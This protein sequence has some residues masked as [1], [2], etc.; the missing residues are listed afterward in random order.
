MIIDIPKTLT[1]R[2]GRGARA[3]EKKVRHDDSVF[4]VQ[5]VGV[6]IKAA[7]Q[8]ILHEWRA[9]N[10]ASIVSTLRKYYG[11][12]KTLSVQLS[13]IKKALSLL[14]SPPPAPFFFANS[15]LTAATSPTRHA[16]GRDPFAPCHK[17]HSAGTGAQGTGRLTHHRTHGESLQWLPKPF[18]H[19][20]KI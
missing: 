12:L 14:P 7:K 8:M 19:H 15:R 13:L 9:M 6:D 5:N 11:N 16:S 10:P 18:P 20:S 4:V 17:Y 3:E 2:H 1:P